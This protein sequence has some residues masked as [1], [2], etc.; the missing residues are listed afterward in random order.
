MEHAR[1]V[2]RAVL[3]LVVVVAVVTIGRS[4]LKP[5]SYGLYGSYRADNVG[6]QM[7]VRAP[8]HG[9]AASCTPCHAERAKQREAGGHKTVSCE[10]C[11]APLSRHVTDGQRTAAMPADPS[12]ALC[13]RC[14]RKVLG[15]PVKFP[16]VILEQHVDGK[17]E[18]KVCLGC[19]DPHSP[20]P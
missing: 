10:V 2:F 7:G 1:H 3:A 15:R 8:R 18:G 12:F 11:H 4:F 19:H 5:R 20:K 16:Q 13:A 17:V 14:H 9:G 6:E